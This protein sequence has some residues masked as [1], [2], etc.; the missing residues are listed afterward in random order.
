MGVITLR[1]RLLPLVSLRAMFGMSDQELTD[2]NRVLVIPLHAG[3]ARADGPAVGVVV[4]EMREVLRV[5]KDMMDALPAAIANDPSMQEISNICRLEGGKRLVSV[6]SPEK[7][8]SN[9][10]M[11]IAAETYSELNEQESEVQQDNQTDQNAIED[12]QLVVFRL[13]KEEYGAPIHL[14]KE[15]VRVPEKLTDIPGAPDIFEGV[16]NLRGSVLPVVDMRR[17]F[18]LTSDERNDRQRIMVFEV[19]QR[20]VGFIVDSV[21]EV[22]RI[23]DDVI[24]QAPNMSDEQAGVIAGIVNLEAVNRMILLLEV[25]GLLSKQQVEQS[26][27]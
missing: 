22:L 10:L 27:R 17:R 6:I 21:I 2:H 25:D 24:E 7:L 1:D 20:R 15:I 5:P 26:R 3:K 8:L 14:V 23:A 4:D 19:H 11:V 18:G 9:H 16:I 13:Q 12:N